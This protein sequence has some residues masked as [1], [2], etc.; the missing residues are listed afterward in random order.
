[1]ILEKRLQ[2]EIDQLKA[3]ENNRQVFPGSNE[4]KFIIRE[5]QKLLNLSGNDY[6]GLASENDFLSTEKKLSFQDLTS[7][8]SRLLTGNSLAY[9]ELE[10]AIS[11]SYAKSCLV[12]N[13]GYHANTGILPALCTKNDVILAD[14]LVHASLIDGIRLSQ[15]QWLRFNHM[16]YDQLERLIQKHSETAENIFV[17]VE[18]IYSMDGDVTNL[19]KLVE[20]KKKYGIILYVDEAHAAGIRGDKGLGLAEEQNCLE[21]IDVITGTFGKALAS[22]GAYTV[23][24]AVVKEYLINRCRTLIFTTALPPVSVYHSIKTWKLSLVS[25]EKRIHLRKLSDYFREQLQQ[26]GLKTFGDSHIVPLISGD[27]ASAIE[28]SEKLKNNGFLAMPIRHPAVP[29]GTARI[30]FSLSAT[31]TKDDID[32][33]LNVL[34]QYRS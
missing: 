32:R 18:S 9:H 34:K 28:L 12:F 21:E 10:L 11:A 8:S 30:R 24:S 15:A 5:G 13:S 3:S 16:D 2:E 31:L 4:G 29:K 20:F 19:N 25:N 6:L 22:V 27:N 33:V 7:S 1:M 14:K 26:M 23:C 17:V